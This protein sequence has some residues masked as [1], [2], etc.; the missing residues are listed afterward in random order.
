MRPALLFF[1]FF[2]LSPPVLSSS[3]SDTDYYSKGLAL[4]KES[5]QDA[6]N[7]WI[8]VR[9]S[10]RFA[11]V[12][13]PRVGFEAIRIVTEQ[14]NS[15]LFLLATDLYYW[16][17][18]GTD[19]EN[20][21]EDVAREVERIRPIISRERYQTW[22]DLIDSDDERIYQ[23]IL[24]YWLDRDLT[25]SE[26]TNQRLIEHWQRI[27]H[28]RKNFTRNSNSAFG[29][30]DRGTIY[31][32]YGKPNTR[33][34]GTLTIDRF[35]IQY[36]AGEILATSGV[37][38]SSSDLNKIVQVA[39]QVH[40][41]PEFEIW[42]YYNL[43][44][45]RSLDGT[46]IHI[47][48]SSPSIGSFSEL[49][50]VDDFIPRRAYTQR[51]LLLG[52]L[53]LSIATLL[54]LTYYQQLSATDAFFGDMFGNIE[55]ESISLSQSSRNMA[56]ITAAQNRIAVTSRQ[57]L[58]PVEVS[59]V[60]NTI[61]EVN[62]DYKLAR[63][64]DPDGNNIQ[65]VFVYSDPFQALI[66]DAII[67]EETGDHEP[68]YVLNHNLRSRTSDYETLANVDDFPELDIIYDPITEQTTPVQ[69]I[70]VIPAVDENDQVRV[71][72]Q[73]QDHNKGQ[74]LRDG[75]LFRES[76]LASGR[77][78]I[79]V[80]EPLANKSDELMVSDLI[81][82]FGK[83]NED[84]LRAAQ[85]S[86]GYSIPFHVPLKNKIPQQTGISLFFETYNI[87]TDENGI[88][89]YTVEYRLRPYTWLGR[90]VLRDLTGLTL[91]LNSQGSRSR[92]ILE[93][94][95]ADIESGRYLL[96]LIV[97]DVKTGQQIERRSDIE[98][99]EVDMES[100]Q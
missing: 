51:Q 52:D 9:D 85:R 61:E 11:E 44:E 76:L 48:G 80:S 63:M 12:H 89:E 2:I 65:M 95:L 68:F 74:G 43:V 1:I 93:I 90:T 75:S 88:G 55:A 24:G 64:I 17:L 84:E 77:K 13:D 78:E 45:G 86:E 72:A 39:E 94:D 98:I 7:H 32:K 96:Q 33:R 36:W 54:Q 6:L 91:N 8:A 35:K 10:L 49:E 27:A 50:A 14:N 57:Y 40:E 99:V 46:T 59:A 70:F 66:K 97:T 28:A 87:T 58:A 81:L 21:K 15:N 18:R 67:L 73:V 83:M 92:D 100:F 37:N 41:Y 82:G 56:M 79:E 29:T 4:E 53:R 25:P 69:S 30:D 26:L 23:H 5:W 47:F 22:K 19:L 71:V 42:V 34:R 62:I 31:V 38:L 20:Y 3:A 16:G 60:E